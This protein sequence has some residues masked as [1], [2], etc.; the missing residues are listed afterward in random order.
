MERDG[1]PATIHATDW[2]RVANEHQRT[3]FYR[4]VANVEGSAQS[5][6]ANAD[7]L[8]SRGV[9]LCLLERVSARTAALIAAWQSVG[10][11]HG[12]RIVFLP[13]LDVGLAI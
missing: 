13:H 8:D 9:V 3:C 11:A 7:A 5:C 1:D 2:S 4:G 12:M 10:F 6:A